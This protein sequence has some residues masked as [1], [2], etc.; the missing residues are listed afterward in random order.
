MDE[1]TV[2][3]CIFPFALAAGALSYFLTRRRKP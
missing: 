1:L 3:A 2:M